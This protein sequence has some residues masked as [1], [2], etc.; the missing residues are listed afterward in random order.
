MSN[1]AF[2]KLGNISCTCLCIRTHDVEPVRL[3]RSDW[4]HDAHCTRSLLSL[5][6]VRLPWVAWFCFCLW[7]G[8]QYLRLI[9]SYGLKVSKI[10]SN[11]KAFR[12]SRAPFFL[13]PLYLFMPLLMELHRE[14]KPWR[15]TNNYPESQG[16]WL[17]LKLCSAGW[18]SKNM[19][20]HTICT[21]LEYS[22]TLA[23]SLSTEVGKTD[24]GQLLRVT[25]MS[26]RWFTTCHSIVS[27][28]VD[29]CSTFN[30]ITWTH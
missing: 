19:I 18:I 22:F 1:S 21:L 3:K 12:I 13:P 20:S 16:Q 24:F 27:F 17:G 6:A 4:K 11:G 30:L 14:T 10:S 8:K 9:F 7:N 25:F 29:F 5:L 28:I 23:D 15:N 2:T 26:N